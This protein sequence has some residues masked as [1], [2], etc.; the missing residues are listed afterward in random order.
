MCNNKAIKMSEYLVTIICVISVFT[1]A[2]GKF[3]KYKYNMQL[4]MECYIKGQT[5]ITPPR[6]K[7][8]ECRSK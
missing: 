2:I 8:F 7:H 5:Q 4:F 3:V 1:L 6:R